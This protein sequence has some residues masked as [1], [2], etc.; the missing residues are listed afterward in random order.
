V[1][2]IFAFLFNTSVDLH[3]SLTTC[4]VTLSLVSGSVGDL[5][6]KINENL[7]NVKLS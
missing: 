6:Y 4:A 1:L 3:E 7:F 2:K 5:V